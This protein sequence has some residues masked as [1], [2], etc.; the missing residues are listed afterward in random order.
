[1]SKREFQFETLPR[2]EKIRK[3]IRFKPAKEVKP[4]RGEWARDKQA[5][6]EAM[7]EEV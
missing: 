5:R 3:P 1:M 7:R 6:R 4:T 2:V